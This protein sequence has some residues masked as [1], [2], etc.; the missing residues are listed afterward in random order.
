MCLCYWPEA[1]NQKLQQA[2]SV[3]LKISK[4]YELSWNH[5][6]ARYFLG[7]INYERNELD[8]AVVHLEVIVRDPYSFPIQS[9]THCSILLSL[10]YQ[11]LGQADRACE[12]A[13]S[14]AKLAF[15]RGNKMFIDLIESFQADLDLRQGRLAQA[16]QW[17]RAF[18]APPPHGMQRYFN[19]ELTSIKI[20][21]ARNTPASLKS[22]AEQLDSMHKLV[23]QV[24]HRRL[25]IDVLGMKALLE[26]A[27]GQELSAFKCLEEALELAGPREFIRPFLDLGPPMFDLIKRLAKLKP[28]LEYT[29]KI[30]AAFSNEKAGNLRDV[31]DDPTSKQPSELSQTLIEPLTNREIEILSILA[32]RLSNDVIAQKLFI[33]PETVKR[34]LYN[35]YQK[36]GVKNRQQAIAKA[37]STGM[38]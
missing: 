10:T 24:H 21:I 11:A 29:G 26:D 13:N 9:L 7:L 30:L 12:V 6:F 19:A 36:L 17:V 2:A 1:D 28:D 8:E 16:E 20:L 15:E 22:A 37:E 38:L 25:L 5:S 23:T 27:L 18:V 3:L 32:K 4:K 14:I 31:F 35:I 34:H 33:S